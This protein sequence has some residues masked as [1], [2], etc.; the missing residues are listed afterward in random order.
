MEGGDWPGILVH[1]AQSFGYVDGRQKRQ[2]VVGRGWQQCLLQVF[3][4]FKLGK[5]VRKKIV[6]VWSF[7]IG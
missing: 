7:T 4:A 5:V 2:Q 1:V 6:K 3:C